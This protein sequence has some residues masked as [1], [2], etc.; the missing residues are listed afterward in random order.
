MNRRQLITLIAAL[1]T[2]GAT[3]AEDR[4]ELRVLMIGNSYTGQTRA[5]VKAF[6]EADPAIKLEFVT[7]TPGDAPF[8]EMLHDRQRIFAARAKRVPYLSNGY[9][10]V[11]LDKGDDALND[12]LI[13][14][15][16]KKD[17]FAESHQHTLIEQRT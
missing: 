15:S 7:H 4:Q 3:D 6:L 5:E 10:A 12:F 17:I 11:L 9:A 8:V 14:F 13:G 1:L 2:S 16:L